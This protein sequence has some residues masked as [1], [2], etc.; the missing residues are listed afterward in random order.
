M[1]NDVQRYCYRFIICLQSKSTT[2]PRELY[3]PLPIVSTSQEDININFVLGLLRIVKGFDSIFVVVN[4]LRI[5]TNF[6]SYHK[7]DDARNI[8]KLFFRDLI[9]LHG[10]PRT[11]ISDRDRISQSLLEVLMV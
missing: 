8:E 9:K 11:I 4:R 2:M 5:M 3:T 1:R 6:I 7:I 10:L